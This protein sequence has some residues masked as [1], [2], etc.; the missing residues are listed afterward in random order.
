MAQKQ[1]YDL[2]IVGA[3][4]CGIMAAI[5]ANIR[6]SIMFDTKNGAEKLAIT[7]NNRCNLTNTLPLEEFLSAYNRNGQFLRSAF[8]R[9]FSDD[10]IRFVK[11]IGFETETDSNRIFLKN[12]TSK[13][14]AK[15]LLEEAQK[16]LMHFK[17]FE[18]VI[19]VDLV[20]K[21]FVLHTCKGRYMAQRLLLACGGAS[22]PQTGSM[23][24]CYSLA[25]KFGHTIVAPQPAEVP[26]CSDNTAPLQGIALKGVPVKL[27]TGS[28]VHSTRGDILFTHF[29]LSGPAIL[30]LSCKNFTDAK[31]IINLI[32]MSQKE[33]KKRIEGF[34]GTPGSFFKRLLPNRIVDYLNLP[35]KCFQELSKRDIH[36][37]IERVTSFQ[38]NVRKCP[39]EK[40]F[41]TVGG[42]SVKQINP[43][44]M[45]S[46]LVKNLFFCGEIIDISGPIGGFNL[47][48]AFSTGF[49]AGKS[50]ATAKP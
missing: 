25:K 19:R 47:Q 50:I 36:S 15:K 33:L 16:R 27:K 20:K 5:Q 23:G 21:Y 34:R 44:T 4:V 35:K 28:S 13:R 12:A 30:E 17:K 7:G 48:A 31:I 43:E 29:G 1:I 41:V 6:N 49:L 3:G 42:V 8:R 24:I 46:K 40:A 39:L 38:L 2:A 45:E 22:Y 14:F 11:K 10:L 18:A 32:N 37:I 26:L 9:F